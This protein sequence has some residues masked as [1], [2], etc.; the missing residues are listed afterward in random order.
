[1]NDLQKSDFS[2]NQDYYASHYGRIFAN[3]KYYKL[4]SLYWKKAI[5][6]ANDIDSR[7]SILDYGCGLGQVSDSLVNVTYFDSSEFAV[8]FLKE[9][10]RKVVNSIE[11]IP[12]NEFDF[13]LSSHSLEHS[14]SPKNELQSFHN[15]VKRGGKLILILPVEVYL[16][17][18]LNPDNDRHFYCWTF[19]TI[20]NLLF[21]CDWRPVFQN[22][23][24]GPFLLN[25]LG[26]VLDE[27][28]A[29][30]IAH[31]LGKLKKNYPSIMTIAQSVK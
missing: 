25:K 7:V 21:H 12:Q 31:L 18:S 16:K 1:M 30:K 11:N 19:Q 28:N 22:K 29:V 24:Y 9:R 23:L 8:N 15:Y 27:K 17:P 20:T 5:F 2:Y 26:S 10:G 4:L 3:D 13:L 14:S 6:D